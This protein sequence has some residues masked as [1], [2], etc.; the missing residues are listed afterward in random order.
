MKDNLLGVANLYDTGGPCRLW[1]RAQGENPIR[2]T[3]KRLDQGYL[4]ERERASQMRMLCDFICHYRLRAPLVSL[5]QIKII[6]EL[7]MNEQKE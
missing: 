6:W 2:K 4:L 5:I 3:N 1:S 7:I